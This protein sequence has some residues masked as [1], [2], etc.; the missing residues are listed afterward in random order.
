MHSISAIFFF[1]RKIFNLWTAHA[2]NN[3]PTKKIKSN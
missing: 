2:M 1:G 3:K